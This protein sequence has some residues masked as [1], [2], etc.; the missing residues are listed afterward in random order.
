MSN[1]I[2]QVAQDLKY[3][4]RDT[5]ERITYQCHHIRMHDES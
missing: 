1:F 5:E 2:L 4:A 3:Q